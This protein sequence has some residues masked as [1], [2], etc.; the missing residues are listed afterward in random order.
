M[1]MIFNIKIVSDKCKCIHKYCIPFMWD[2]FITANV[3]CIGVHRTVLCALDKKKR[4]GDTDD[5]WENIQTP[6]I[7]VLKLDTLFLLPS[8]A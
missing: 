5:C 1:G 4:M 2:Q 8:S 6:E 7:S 3:R